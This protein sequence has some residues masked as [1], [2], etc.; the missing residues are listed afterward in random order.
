MTEYEPLE[1]L[2]AGD[3]FGFDFAIV[4]ED[5]FD[6]FAPDPSDPEAVAADEIED[7]P[8]MKE[9]PESARKP[10]V[11]DKSRFESAQAAIRELFRRNPSRMPVFLKIIEFCNDERTTTEVT[12]VV[13]EFQKSC[14]SVY[15][16][17]SLCRMLEKSGALSC[18]LPENAEE[19]V[20]EEG[21]EYL[22]IKEPEEALW[23]ATDDGLTV[24]SE[25]RAGFELD[26][27][28]AGRE[29]AYADVYAEVIAFLH[30]RGR[31][32]GELNEKL[33]G[34]ERLENP[35]KDPMHFLDCLQEVA[36]VEW[37]DRRWVLTEL[38]ENYF[39]KINGQG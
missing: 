10:S 31:T 3:G 24:L 16:A 23:S 18:R 13:D 21:V 14:F 4:D 26:E 2:A 17:M 20:D 36:A 28:L 7:L 8:V 33:A 11:Y 32:A 30:E 29:A 9:L 34:D 6:P 37:R 22:E 19:A 25:C 27:M 5:E 15:S 35:H 39:K 1:E 38:G 12:E